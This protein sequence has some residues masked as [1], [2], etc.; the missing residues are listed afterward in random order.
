[1]DRRRLGAAGERIAAEYLG[2]GGYDIIDRNWRSGP[3]EIDI[4]AARDGCFAFV[5]V[6]TRRSVAFG[7]ALESVNE[8]KRRNMRRAARRWLASGNAASWREVRCDLVAIDIDED[9]L[10]LRH[11]RGIA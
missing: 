7:R 3:L 4:V 11:L 9:G 1:M 2:L 10:S 8:R 5:E 6:K